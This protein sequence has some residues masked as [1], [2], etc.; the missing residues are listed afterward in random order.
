MTVPVG[1]LDNGLP[2]RLCQVAV[3]QP[4]MDMTSAPNRKLGEGE[5]VTA[6][7][8][9]LLLIQPA[10]CCSVSCCPSQSTL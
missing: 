5:T 6:M 10:G 9:L 7:M 2:L 3:L 1:D 8:K 4:S